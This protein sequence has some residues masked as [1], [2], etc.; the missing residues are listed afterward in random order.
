M[1]NVFL[2]VTAVFPTY[3]ISVQKFHLGKKKE[4]WFWWPHWN[5]S[6]KFFLV[7]LKLAVVMYI[8][9]PPRMRQSLFPCKLVHIGYAMCL[10]TWIGLKPFIL[11]ETL[12]KLILLI[13]TGHKPVFISLYSRTACYDKAQSNI[14]SQWIT[15][16]MDI[17]PFLEE[18]YQDGTV[19]FQNI[20]CLGC[21]AL[22]NT[23]EFKL[24]INTIYYETLKLR[25]CF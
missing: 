19:Q 24:A 22:F 7:L 18:F 3:L 15:K 9:L 1:E 20:L 16:H 6:A 12:I 11:P 4:N 25:K 10:I 17:F 14:F 2:Q 13:Q 21:N 23:L 5:K 8:Y